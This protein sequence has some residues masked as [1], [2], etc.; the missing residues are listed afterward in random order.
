MASILYGE[1]YEP[2]LGLVI[3]LEASTLRQ[4]FVDDAIPALGI[5]KL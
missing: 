4:P 1:L 2:H 5:A 3:V